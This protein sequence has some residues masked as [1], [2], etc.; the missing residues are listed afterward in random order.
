MLELLPSGP[1]LAVGFVAFFAIVLAGAVGVYIDLRAR[2]RVAA[3]SVAIVT[4]AVLPIGL[5]IWLIVRVSL[6]TKE[7][8]K[9]RIQSGKGTLR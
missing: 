1:G 3:I 9:G 6:R 2:S 5:L 4:I 7:T 8:R